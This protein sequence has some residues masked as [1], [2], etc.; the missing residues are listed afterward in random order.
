LR[1]EL[2]QMTEQAPVG[3]QAE[4]WRHLDAALHG[5]FRS[6]VADPELRADLVQDVLLRMHERWDQL[7]EHGSIDAWAFRIARNALIDHYRRHR[8]SEPLGELEADPEPE[9]SEEVPRVLGTWLT[10]QIAALPPRYR[11]ALELT[12]LRGLSQREAARQLGVA[13]STFKSRVQRGRDLLHAD[14]LRC[15]AVE[16]DARGRVMEFA[17]RTGRDGNDCGCTPT[18]CD[19]G[20]RKSSQ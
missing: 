20:K 11:E 4:Q 17:P 16:I 14:L 8:G 3:E 1:T 13:E 15:C 12:E 6:R 5:F 10:M 2:L 9:S 19:P 18:T 7:R